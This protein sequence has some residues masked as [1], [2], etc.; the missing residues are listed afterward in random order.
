GFNNPVE[1]VMAHAG[2]SVVRGTADIA[3][4][5]YNAGRNVYGMA[6]GQDMGPRQ[7][8]AREFVDKYATQDTRA[9]DARM[10]QM[11]VPG[12]G[13]AAGT[14]D[15]VGSLVGPASVGQAAVQGVG[16]TLARA[17]SATTM[18]KHLDAARRYLADVAPVFQRYGAGPTASGAKMSLPARAAVG[19]G[20][21][22]TA[23]VATNPDSPQ[24]IGVGAAGGAVLGPTMHA[25][26]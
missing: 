19:A 11:G 3:D 24:A 7:Q 9:A 18:G 16:K 21:G 10:R 2:N 5:I 14:A 17:S 25:A 23:A 22:A 20:A 26:S 13:F 6:T 12:Y 8:P 15:V 1:G 4:S